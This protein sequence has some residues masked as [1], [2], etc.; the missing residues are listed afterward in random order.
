MR[1]VGSNIISTFTPLNVTKFQ[2][3]MLMPN[4]PVGSYFIQLHKR[5]GEMS[6]NSGGIAQKFLYYIN[7]TGLENSIGSILGGTKLVLNT[8]GPTGFNDSVYSQNKVCLSQP[9]YIQSFHF[10]F[11]SIYVVQARCVFIFFCFLAG[12]LH[13]TYV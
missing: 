3:V 8:T 10:I 12:L 6:V 13:L 5:N 4:V 1:A 2:V 9:M 7:I 11:K